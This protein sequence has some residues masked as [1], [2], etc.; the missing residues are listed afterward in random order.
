MSELNICLSIYLSI[1]L[2]V[3]LS[4]CLSIYLSVY[5]SIYLSICLSVYLFICLSVYLSIYRSIYLSIYLSV[6]ISIITLANSEKTC[7]GSYVVTLAAFVAVP[8]W[9]VRATPTYIH[10]HM[11][12]NT[13]EHRQTSLERV[14]G[15]LN[16]KQRICMDLSSSR[17]IP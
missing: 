3:C 12:H 9:T 17:T 15:A 4:I 1:Y 2:S 7:A 10:I 13:I 11:I 6:Y 5:L 16:L 14:P 8:T